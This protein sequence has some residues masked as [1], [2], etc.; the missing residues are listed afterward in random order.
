IGGATEG[1]SNVASSL[2]SPLSLA[3]MAASGGAVRGIPGA[4]MLTRALSL[5]IAA[6]GAYQ[7][8]TGKTPSEQLFGA[9]E[10]AGGGAGM[11]HVPPIRGGRIKSISPQLEPQPADFTA[12][13]PAE[14]TTQP[15][16]VDHTP[17]TKLI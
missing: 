15:D 8:A 10:M 9:A 5:P 12:Q 7:V 14:F 1:L 3:T 13:Q 17:P 2:T 4:S 6:H 11:F 16:I